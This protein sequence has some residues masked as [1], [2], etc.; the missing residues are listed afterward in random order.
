MQT[1]SNLSFKEYRR[2]RGIALLE[3][4]LTS[5]APNLPKRSYFIWRHKGTD[6]LLFVGDTQS[7]RESYHTAAV[8][9][10]Q[11]DDEDA[12]FVAQLSYKTA[13]FLATDP[14]S[15]PAQIGAWSDVLLRATDDNIRQKAVEQI[16]ALG[17][18][19]LAAENGQVTVRYNPDE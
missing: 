17:G 8:W 19:I 9:A 10:E 6:E 7:A 4:G 12:A 11:S 5:M 13:E 15:K 14:N 18:K 2:F 16:E 3:K 1:P